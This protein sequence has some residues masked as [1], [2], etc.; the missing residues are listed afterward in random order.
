MPTLLTRAMTGEEARTV[1][2]WSYPA[3]FDLY[4]VDPDDTALFTDRDDAGHGYYPA[5][6]QHGAVV[7]FCVLGP[8]ARVRGQHPH[9]HGL[10]VGLGVRPDLVSRGLASELLPQV[11]TLAR[12]LFGPVQLRTAVATF[13]ERSLALC[14]KAGFVAVRDFTGPAGRTFRELVRP[15]DR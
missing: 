2:A 15:L 3:P 1:A 12:D 9:E 5:L 4:D 6:D 7:A 11:A 8:E 10:D 13:N 14:R